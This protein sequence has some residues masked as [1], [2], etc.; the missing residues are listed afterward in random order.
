MK[1]KIL[2][3]IIALLLTTMVMPASVVLATESEDTDVNVEVTAEDLGESEEE[4][5][6][7]DEEEAI[8]V[9]GGG[10]VIEVGNTTAEETTIIVRI[11]HDDST[12]EDITLEITADTEIVDSNGGSFD[13]SNI[14]AGDNISYLSLIHI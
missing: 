12:T 8:V 10:M 14:I 5:N 2:Q 13:L 6:E 7:A 9:N 3:F 1:S 11:T 4:I